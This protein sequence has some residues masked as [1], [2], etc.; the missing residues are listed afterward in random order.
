MEN[1]INI[2]PEFVAN[3]IA[4][5]EVV[6]RPS[7]AVKELLENAVDAGAT[8]IELHIQDAGRTLVQVIDNGC[9]MNS[10]DA[11]RCF[12]PHATSKLASAEDLNH[13]RTLGFRGEA[14]ASIAAVAQVELLTR[15]ENEELGT[16]I[17]IEGN[18]I[19]SQEPCS[20]P[21][22]S[23]F[24]VRNI[25]FNTPARRQFLKSDEVEYRYVEDEFN[26][27]VLAHPEIAFLLYKNDKK[28]YHLEAS[29]LKKR[30]TQLMGKSYDSRLIKL[31]EAIPGMKIAGY[32]CT[33]DY[34]IKG[35]SKHFLFANR[36]FIKHGGLSNAIE[37][38]YQGLIPEGKSPVFFL[39]IDVEPENIDVNIH[40]TK[41]EIRFKDEKL[42]YGVML[43]A[44]KHSLGVNQIRTVLD[45]ESSENLPYEYR[46]QN[47]IPPAPTVRL[48]P[49]YNPFSN[50]SPGKTSGT[51]V[52]K[53]GSAADRKTETFIQQGGSKKTAD[54]RS[55]YAENFAMMQAR[56]REE[57]KPNQ[58][59]LDCCTEIE[60]DTKIPD[61][62]PVLQETPVQKTYSAQTQERNTDSVKV[63]QMF[64]RYI[65]A[66]L[67][68]GLAVIDQ[69]A[70]SERIIFND[71]MGKEE[72][73]V[74]SQSTL[75]PQTIEL[76]PAHSE[77]L[78][79]IREELNCLGW[80]IEWIGAHAFMLNALP[81]QIQEGR[82]AEI[83]ESI[84]DSYAYNLLHSKTSKEE[85][86]ASATARQLA[87]KAGTQ[88]TQEE[89]L[90]IVN[91][92][93]SGKS[94]EISPSGKKIIRVFSLQE[95][96]EIF[97]S[98]PQRRQQP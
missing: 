84:L 69:E 25:Y 54:Y 66:P 21:K 27:I 9:G 67:K 49:E 95:L 31:S 86:V 3:Q 76:S 39:H 77:L 89:I 87:I 15:S 96:S 42:M 92:L 50:A 48:N 12:L 11:Q 78:L 30:I 94:P 13:I 20:C 16:R 98:A 19:K 82:S 4:A 10:E 74:V 75:F 14:L 62:S 88:L 29:N 90:Y 26:R 58:L 59:I 80:S 55:S 38:A 36:R 93:F 5:G 51:G 85:N 61:A 40:P 24:K 32:I 6:N 64:D 37:K 44:V 71:Y 52:S 79:E 56:M 83:L 45:F 18:R 72:G 33:P 47:Y 63:F 22:G 46:S 23:C 73:Q 2:L 1:I 65:I 70:A 91:R 17:C 68:S 57:E 53:S 8:E 41:T 34:A 97:D 81:A 28:I 35:R 60:N 43:S 7:S